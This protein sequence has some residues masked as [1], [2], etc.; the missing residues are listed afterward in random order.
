MRYVVTD[1]DSKAD[2][3]TRQDTKGLLGKIFDSAT[4][5]HMLALSHCDHALE[6]LVNKG[7]IDGCSTILE[8]VVDWRGW[9]WITGW[10]EIKAYWSRPDTMVLLAGY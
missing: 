5:R 9:Y 7:I 10:G 2:L 3:W 8:F 1:L 6:Y 4:H